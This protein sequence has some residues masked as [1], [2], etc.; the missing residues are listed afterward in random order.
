MSR[1]TKDR[2]IDRIVAAALGDLFQWRRPIAK[3]S[4]GP[5]FPEVIDA[6][7]VDLEKLITDIRSLLWGHDV[8]RLE[9]DFQDSTAPAL[10][11]L[12]DRN[13]LYSDIAERLHD[14]KR[15]RPPDF[16]GG[17]A[18][19]E[20]E[21]DLPYWRG[22]ASYT[23]SEAVLL[24]VGRDPRY[25]SFD[26]VTTMYGRSDQID[27]LLYFLE[28]LYESVAAGLGV[29]PENP[30]ACVDAKSLLR[31]VEDKSIRIDARFRRMLRE[32]HNTG[33]GPKGPSVNDRVHRPEPLH[34]SSLKVHA[35]IVGAVAI[36]KYG[37]EGK[38]SIGRVAKKIEND[39]QL[40]G[41]S[42]DARTVRSLLK[43]ALEQRDE[44]G[45]T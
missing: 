6:F 14:L 25:T 42:F 11:L 38:D 7:E 43:L 16:I 29:D 8:D 34:R 23:L 41:L 3:P 9:R 31:W 19:A 21:I 1:G 18:I 39:G 5:S 44:G 24:C 4:V 28:D 27:E 15:S 10:N 17:W 35:R 36:A 22:A 37:L 26:G 12:F 33:D 20:R 2:I 30:Q 32:Y 45:D 40:Q 13:G